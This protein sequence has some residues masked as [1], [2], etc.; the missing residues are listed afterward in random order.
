[1]GLSNKDYEEKRDFIRMTMNAKATMSIS[2]GNAFDVKVIDLSATGMHLEASKPVALT[3]EVVVNV[4]SP[5]AQFES[6]TA[7][8]IVVRCLELNESKFD[9]GLEV[10]SIS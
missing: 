7:Q 10:K 9:I 1:M 3:T 8:C 6:M 2:E 4:E 5:N